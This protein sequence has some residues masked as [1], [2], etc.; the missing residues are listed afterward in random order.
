[1]PV[2]IC[3]LAVCSFFGRRYRQC[4]RYCCRFHQD[5]RGAGAVPRILG[6]GTAVLREEELRC[7]QEAEEKWRSSGKIVQSL[8]LEGSN[9]A[10]ILRICN[11]T[12]IF[13]PE[14]GIGQHG[15]QD[16]QIGGRSK[17][18]KITKIETMWVQKWCHAGYSLSGSY[19]RPQ[20]IEGER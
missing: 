14:S 6:Q 20:K 12:N 10:I 4:G 17:E 3:A 1:M 19:F 5:Y 15:V 13:Q 18:I 11:W 7:G 8:H 16:L 2:S 9:I